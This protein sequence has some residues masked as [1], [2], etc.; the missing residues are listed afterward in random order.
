MS[1]SPVQIRLPIQGEEQELCVA[2]QQLEVLLVQFPDEV[3]LQG[4]AVIVP[5]D[6]AEAMLQAEC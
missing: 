1:L 6:L 5:V 3:I 4:L 2:L